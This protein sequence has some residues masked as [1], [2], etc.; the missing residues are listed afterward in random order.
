MPRLSL[1]RRAASAETG[2][3]SREPTEA[4]CFD[5]PSDKFEADG[6]PAVLTPDVET[7]R[8]MG[9]ARFAAR[10]LPPSEVARVCSAGGGGTTNLSAIEEGGDF[11][12]FGRD[13]RVG[14]L[15]GDVD[16]ESRC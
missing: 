14:R 6:V 16:N 10:G 9:N 11:G 3:S 15:P 8:L 2:R 4:P 1:R 5:E 13:V 12:D 7:L